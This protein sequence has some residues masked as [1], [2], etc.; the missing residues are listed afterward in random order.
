M[1]D[2]DEQLREK[3]RL[4]QIKLKRKIRLSKLRLAVIGMPKTFGNVGSEARRELVQKTKAPTAVVSH[5]REETQRRLEQEK[6]FI[7]TGRRINPKGSTIDTR[8]RKKLAKIRQAL[9]TKGNTTFQSLPPEAITDVEDINKNIKPIKG[10]GPSRKDKPLPRFDKTKERLK[11]LGKREDIDAL[12]RKRLEKQRKFEKFKTSKEHGHSIVFRGHPKGIFRAASLVN[13]DQRFAKY[14]LLNAKQING[15][16][17][18]ISQHTARENMQKFIGR[19]LVITSSHWHGASEYGTRFEHPYLPTDDMNLI[20]AHQDKFKVGIITG[21]DE[22]KDGDFHAII[23]MLPKFAGMQLPPFCSPA[24]YQLDASEKEGNISKWEALHLAGLDENPAYGARIAILKGTCLGTANA[25]SI[26]F[27]SAKFTRRLGTT[28]RDFSKNKAPRSNIFKPTQTDSTRGMQN[29]IDLNKPK[30]I[31]KAKPTSETKFF[32]DS[33][34]EITKKQFSGKIVCPVQVG[35]IKTRLAD[36]EPDE[37]FDDFGPIKLS[38]SQ[39]GEV[40]SKQRTRGIINKVNRTITKGRKHLDIPSEGEGQRR[41][42]LTKKITSQ[43]PRIP[44]K[45]RRAGI[46]TIISDSLEGFPTAP[47]KKVLPL[48][49]VPP[50]KKLPPKVIPPLKDLR[51]RIAAITV[52]G[53]PKKPH[54][55]EDQKAL[56]SATSGFTQRDLKKNKK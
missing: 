35:K 50:L 7:N 8:L 2:I 38:P 11:K 33:G 23:E 28:G 3:E 25:C 24:I 30:N 20:F 32:D 31:I 42:D 54:T 15:N 39:K 52:F 22:N 10:T 26:Q 12:E 17:W 14:W 1:T 6:D 44:F 9:I 56:D 21:I 16:G 34:K 51:K 36:I 13:Q 37:A 40:L 29:L 27:K 43:T 46:H 41:K 48:K 19:P 5:N 18:G 53:K 49:K 55:P 45:N 47:A 4:K